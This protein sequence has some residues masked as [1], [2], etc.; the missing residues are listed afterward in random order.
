LRF[1]GPAARDLLSRGAF[2]DFH[3]SAFG[4]GSTAVTAIAHIGIILWQLDDTPAFEVAL[5]RSYAASF[6]RWVEMTCAAAGV[7]PSAGA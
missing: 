7:E 3:P 5:F 6:W 4:P 1:S 2:I